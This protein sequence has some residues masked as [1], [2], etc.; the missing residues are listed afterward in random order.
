MAESQRDRVDALERR[1]LTTEAA[2]RRAVQAGEKKLHNDLANINRETIGDA[3]VRD[4]RSLV[5]R[6]MLR[7]GEQAE[8]AALHERCSAASAER[9]DP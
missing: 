2:R 4:L 9:L 5:T 8:K 6:W 3:E 7:L 1:L